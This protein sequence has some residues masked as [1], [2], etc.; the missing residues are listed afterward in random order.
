MAKIYAGLREILDNTQ[1]KYTPLMDAT[2]RDLAETYLSKAVSVD[3]VGVSIPLDKYFSNYRR[4]LTWK[5][6][7]T[8]ATAHYE[9]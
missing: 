7:S 6:R 2:E 3:G 5:Q 1:G 4:T 8:Y 9:K